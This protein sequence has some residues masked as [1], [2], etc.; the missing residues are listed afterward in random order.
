MDLN[1]KNDPYV[2][3]TLGTQTAVTRVQLKT[4]DPVWKER[5][6]FGVNSVE[7]QQL[8][9]SVYDYDKFKHDEHI[10]SC[11]V[12]LSHLT[13]EKAEF[14]GETQ[15]HSPVRRRVAAGEGRAGGGRRGGGESAW[16]G[17]GGD[18]WASSHSLASS[19]Q[20]TGT[21][22]ASG[23]G[24]MGGR[25]GAASE[26]ATDLGSETSGWHKSRWRSES[27]EMSGDEGGG[28][29]LMHVS[30]WGKKVRRVGRGEGGVR[31]GG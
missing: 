18:T 10:G 1:G 12:G 31:M 26:A 25:S 27:R 22:R 24:G 2:K 15:L 29:S 13:C 5:F 16:E 4:N 11:T 6:V 19:V 3:L 28:G 7:A 14:R 20:T 8:H 9:L 21:R 23:W 17:E 30:S